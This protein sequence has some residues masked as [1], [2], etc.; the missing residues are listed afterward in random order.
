M[1]ANALVNTIYLA[2]SLQLTALP[3]LSLRAASQRTSKQNWLQ[4]SRVRKAHHVPKF[5]L[6]YIL[7]CT[8]LTELI[9]FCAT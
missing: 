3:G 8:I 6:F 2:N 4:A 5:H 7:P 1:E 9:G